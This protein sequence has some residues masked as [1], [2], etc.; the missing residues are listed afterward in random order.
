VA[1][2]PLRAQRWAPAPISKH[3]TGGGANG[4]QLRPDFHHKHQAGGKGWAPCRAI[5][6]SWPSN[7]RG[8]IDQHQA[9]CSRATA[10]S[11]SVASSQTSPGHPARPQLQPQGVQVEDARWPQALSFEVM[12]QHADRLVGRG[13]HRPARAQACSNMG[14][15]TP[16]TERSCRCRIATEPKGLPIRRPGQPADEGPA[17]PVLAGVSA[18]AAAGPGAPQPI[19]AT[20]NRGKASPSPGRICRGSRQARATRATPGTDQAADEHLTRRG[21]P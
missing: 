4:G 20:Q 19:R 8:L 17:R 14:R 3:R 21:W 10:L 9:R 7:H 1:H 18:T 6:S 5:S 16:S 15:E 13:H 11:A 2:H 12:A